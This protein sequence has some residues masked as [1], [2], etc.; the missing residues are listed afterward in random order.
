MIIMADTEKITINMN[1][2]DLGQIDLLVEQAFY[3]NRT[4]FIKTAIRN[5]LSNHSVEIKDTITRR[6]FALGML[7]YSRKD[8]EDELLKN[9]MLEI[10]VV[11]LLVLNDDIDPNLA[12]KTIKSLKVLGVFK[13]NDK[14]KKA[15]E[16]RKVQDAY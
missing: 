11:G 7:Y 4:D 15:L 9:N 13:A 12:L 14:V 3:S 8:L 16:S 5:Q 1:I 10:K 6:E 2:V